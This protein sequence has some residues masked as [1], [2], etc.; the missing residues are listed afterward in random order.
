MYL[1]VNQSMLKYVK[2]NDEN[3]IFEKKRFIFINLY[4]FYRLNIHG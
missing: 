4:V 1:T 2:P 3:K